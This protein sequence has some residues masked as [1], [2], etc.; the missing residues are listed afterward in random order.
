MFHF[1]IQHIMLMMIFMKV[2]LVWIRCGDNFIMIDLSWTVIKKNV[3]NVYNIN[4][5]KQF[6]I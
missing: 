1:V 4:N 6:R 5:W 3:R 2:N